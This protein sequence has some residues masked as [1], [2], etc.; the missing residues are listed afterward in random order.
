M[1]TLWAGSPIVAP[2]CPNSTMNVITAGIAGW[3]PGIVKHS[4][5]GHWEWDLKSGLIT[6]SDGIFRLLGLEPHSVKPS[7]QFFAS[8]VHP[9]DRPHTALLYSPDRHAER[10]LDQEFRILR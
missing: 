7:L 6:W 5:I 2:H 4:R 3:I 9:A 10:Y 1:P 8:L